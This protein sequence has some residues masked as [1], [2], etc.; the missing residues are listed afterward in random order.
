MDTQPDSGT[1]DLLD[2]YTLEEQA[3]ALDRLLA[4]LELEPEEEEPERWDFMS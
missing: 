2:N 3:L 1:D 4:D